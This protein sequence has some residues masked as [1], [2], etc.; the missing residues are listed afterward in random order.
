MWYWEGVA[1]PE[2][3]YTEEM[4]S[5]GAEMLAPRRKARRR[6][7]REPVVDII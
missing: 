6:D 1:V 2:D 4:D 3:A 7:Q 5:S